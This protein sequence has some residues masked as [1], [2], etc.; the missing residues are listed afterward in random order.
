MPDFAPS[1]PFLERYNKGVAAFKAGRHDEAVAEFQEAI[2]IDSRIVQAHCNLGAALGAKGLQEEAIAE[3]KAALAMDPKHAAS[4]YNLGMRLEAKGR[5]AEAV[6]EFEQFILLAPPKRQGY[7]EDIRRRVETL[8]RILAEQSSPTPAPGPMKGGAGDRTMTM[9]GEEMS[10]DESP[11][12]PS[13]GEPAGGRTLT[14]F[15]PG[16][17]AGQ[18]ALTMGPPGTGGADVRAHEEVSGSTLSWHPGQVIDG[19]Y[20]VQAELGMGGFG[21][22]HKVRHLGW[23]LDLAVKSPRPDRVAN[24][25]ALESFVQEAN[26]WVGLGLHQHI[27]TCYFVRLMG[28]PRIFIEYMEGGTLGEWLKTK[29]TFDI[30]EALD[31]ALQIARAMEY[32]HSKGLVHRDLKP[33]NCLMTP[34][35]VLKVTDFGLA[36]VAGVENIP[37]SDG[38]A[39]GAKIA[40]VKGASQ[41]GR[42]GTPEYMAP[43][44][45]TRP[46]DAG[47]AADA[48]AFGVMLYELCCRKKPFELAEDEP[49]DSFYVRL[50]E[51]DWRYDKP[52]DLP[53]GLFEIISLCLSLD[54]SSRPSDFSRITKVLDSAY[55]REAKTPYFREAVKEVPPLAG[56]LSNQ[57]VSMA[58]LGRADEALR[59]FEQAL[60]LDPMHPGAAYNQGVFQFK[61]GKVS[62]LELIARLKESKRARPGDWAP[63]YL[64]GLLHLRRRDS[65]AALSELEEASFLSRDNALIHKAQRRARDSQ[66]GLSEL[67]LFVD[68]PRGS[69]LTLSDEG[70]YKALLERVEK[71]AA[72]GAYAKAYESL[73]KA[74]S[75][76]GFE[77][78]Q[79][80]MD[81]L[82][83]LSLKGAR[84]KLKAAWQK[85]LLDGSNGATAVCFLPEGKILSGHADKTV[86]L[87]DASGVQ[88]WS[89]AGHAGPVRAVC[90][91]PD[92]KSGLS[93]SADGT[94]RQWNISS[95]ACIR[96][97][98][99]HTGAV[100]SVNVSANG[101]ALSASDDKSLKLW[102]LANGKM[103]KSIPAHGEAATS[104]SLSPDASRAVSGGADKALKVWDLAKGQAAKTLEGHG[105][106]VR[107]ARLSPDGKRALS[108]AEDK[109]LR[110]WSLDF[111]QSLQTMNHFGAVRAA[112]FSPEGRFALSAG[113]DKVM[114]LW[115][116]ESGKQVWSFEGHGAGIS[117]LDISPQARYAVSAGAD[118]IRLW[119]LDWEY[120]FP[121]PADWAE[122]AKPYADYFLAG[123]KDR[124]PS[125]KDPVWTED[126]L[127]GFLSEL[128]RRG[129]GWLNPEGVRSW[130]EALSQGK[131]APGLK[132]SA[133]VSTFTKETDKA[134]KRNLLRW[135]SAAGAVGLLCLGILFLVMKPDSIRESE[136]GRT[137]TAR[138]PGKMSS[139]PVPRT[140]APIIMADPHL[141]EILNRELEQRKKMVVMIGEGLNSVRQQENRLRSEV[142]QLE[143]A[144]ESEQEG[145]RKER[146]RR[147]LETAKTYLAHAKEEAARVQYRYQREHEAMSALMKRISGE[148][149][150]EAVGQAAAAA[151][152]PDSTKNMVIIPAGE[153]LMGSP[154]EEGEAD[155]HPQHKVYLDSYYMDKHEVTVEEYAACVR[156]GT[157]KEPGTQRDSEKCNFGQPGRE[158]HPINCVDWESAKSYCEWAGKRLPTEAEWEKA[159]RGTQAR[160]YP[161]GDEWDRNKLNSASKWAGKEIGDPGTWN[162]YFYQDGKGKAFLAAQTAPIGSYQMDQSLYGV[163][164]MGGNVSE[165]AADWYD[166][167]YY[168]ASPSRNPKGPELPQAYNKDW[169]RI[170]RG[171]SWANFSVGCRAANRGRD[172]P[173]SRGNLLGFRCALSGDAK[174]GASSRTPG[175]GSAAG[176]EESSANAQAQDGAMSDDMLPLLPIRDSDIQPRQRAK[177]L[178]GRPKS[179]EAIRTALVF[180][181]GRQAAPTKKKRP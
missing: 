65:P 12:D 140:D 33:G 8:K 121:E 41:S 85:R 34:G 58:D 36:K 22:V 151:G 111:G 154:K 175:S 45:W 150:A 95:G 152:R 168:E 170:L 155:E 4:H 83:R 56:T 118:G 82:E 126:E 131:S 123:S 108:G 120:V 144:G 119:E 67:E 130:L 156:E 46:Q 57:G 88:L 134:E 92:G 53:G 181:G 40:R 9:G 61:E 38:E 172:E 74:R 28:V 173:N 116:L 145:L 94:L 60:K 11:S 91:V 161:W 162:K 84:S 110:S 30:K 117:S 47:P 3:F 26:T 10:L 101:K 99:G 89:Q 13:S 7:L 23:G 6:T 176:E 136:R 16:A 86:R 157:C 133:A 124:K 147:R 179:L 48:W 51:S 43:E 39:M 178:V 31:I 166:E 62:E 63:S 138:F 21:S 115:D 71:H 77:Q 64:L 54:P 37:V 93:A 102:D 114:R 135:A 164:D 66:G 153:F 24:R 137:V 146:I 73:R 159:A 17:K 52:K 90:A 160:R 149:P 81:L 44:Q 35:G 180:D 69:E 32:S 15:E 18:G 5:F 68:L 112:C 29:K 177:L 163:H 141:R 27:V 107:T 169:R 19:L 98:V 2:R 42:L 96:T 50:L 76:Q 72:S 127:Q 165:W 142:E 143:R 106:A 87:W 167:K 129:L 14:M 97:F 25:R 132:A 55:Q 128:G 100:N 171:G 174:G 79:A 59:L 148:N 113:D 103:E 122:G 75:I 49:V 158:K 20:E 1:G 109:A 70:A 104:A 139:D 80:A 78:A 125:G 105:W